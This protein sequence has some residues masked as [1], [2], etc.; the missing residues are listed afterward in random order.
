MQINLLYDPSV[1]SA[2]AGFQTALAAAAQQIDNLITNPIILN[3][4]VGYGEVNGVPLGAGD[5]GEGG[6]AAGQDV[7]YAQLRSYLGGNSTSPVDASS[8]ANLPAADPTGGS[9]F[10][11]SSSQEKAWGLLAANAT[12]VDGSVGFTSTYPDLNY[13][14]NN[15][16]SPT[17]IDFVGVAEHELTHA[18]GRIAGLMPG[19]YTA[20]D[21]F[22]YSAPGMLQLAG[23]QPAY[24][25]V[26]GGKTALDSFDTVSDYGDWNNASAGPD[27]FDAFADFGVENPITPVDITAMDA[28]GFSVAGNDTPPSASF[29][30]TD[31]SAGSSYAASGVT[32]IGPV[33]GLQTQYINTTAD[34]LSIAATSPD[35]FIHSGAGVDALVAL[36]GIN[37]LDGGTNSNFLVGGSGTD[38]FFVDDRSPAADIWSTVADFRGGDAATVWGV[39]PADFSLTWQDGQGAAGFTGLTLHATAPGVPTASL[40][41]AGYTS[42]DLSNGKLAVS[43]GTDPASGSLFMLVQ[44]NS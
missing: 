33:S 16:S 1:S 20:L 12:G 44:A 31:T 19:G 25:S 39:S 3:I 9:A 23:G 37:V 4:S 21:L 28:I 29:L 43:F 26:D 6:P 11:I 24:F 5:L 41:L 38:T 35:V 40:T 2:P 32:Y 22:R 30:V 42:A 14:P 34:S 13:D 8:V 36:S 15:R 27:L 18:M 10:F 7:T 17:G